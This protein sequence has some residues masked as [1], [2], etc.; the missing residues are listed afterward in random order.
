[1]T[2]FSCCKKSHYFKMEG[3]EGKES[4]IDDDRCILTVSLEEDWTT[5]L[6]AITSNLYYYNYKCSKYTV[7]IIVESYY[8]YIN[9]LIIV[10]H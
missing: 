7:R 9:C 3:I 8:S 6:K 10:W 5:V 2:K 4:A 1:M